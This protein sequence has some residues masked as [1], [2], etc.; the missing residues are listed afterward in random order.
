MNPCICYNPRMAKD[1]PRPQLG[2]FGD[3]DRI[4]AVPHKPAPALPQ[5]LRMGTSSWSFPG[6]R[7]LV[8]QGRHSSGDLAREGLAAYA[9]HPLMRSVSIDRSFYGPPSQREYRHYR[10]QVPD[11]FRFVVKAWRNLTTPVLDGKLNPDFLNPEL[12]T[13]AVIEPTQR[14]LGPCLDSILFQFSPL[15]MG[16]VQGAEGFAEQL[17]RF[18]E[19][20]PATSRYAVEVR[21]KE[22]V[23]A[24]LIQ[25]LASTQSTYTL[26]LIPSMPTLDQQFRA[27]QLQQAPRFLV[28]WLL[29]PGYT[30]Q[31]AKDAFSPFDRLSAPQNEVRDRLVKFIRWADQNNRHF[32]LLVNNKA[33]GCAPLSIQRIAQVLSMK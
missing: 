4:P 32:T 5:R 14:G 10:A 6:W 29:A 15:H 26:N 17:G 27:M 19:A 9:A 8:Y 24:A 21:N 7:G 16:Q 33:E 22:L 2:L 25:A 1:P 31:E 18:L 23:G 28:R 3:P 13:K 11:D 30:Y 12:A 20:L